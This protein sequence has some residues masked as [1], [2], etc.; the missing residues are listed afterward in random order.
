MRQERFTEQAQQ[1]LMASQE[2]VRQHHHNQWAVGHI[3][4]ALLMQ[5]QGLVGDILNELGL[6]VT[7]VRY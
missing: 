2:L 4:L 1:A 5:Q 7:A 6:D 3:L